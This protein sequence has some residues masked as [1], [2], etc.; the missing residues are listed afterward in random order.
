MARDGEPGIWWL[1]VMGRLAPGATREQAAQ[2]LAGTFQA[3]ALEAMPPPR[4]DGDVARLESKDYPRLIAVPGGRGLREHRRYFSRPIYGLFLVVALVLLIAC[5]NLA[6]LLLARAALRRPEIAARLA[7]GAGRGRVVRQLVT[8]AVLLAVLGARRGCA[9][10][11]LGQGGPGRSGRQR[12][13]LSGST[14]SPVSTFACS[15]SRS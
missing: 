13:P 14:S 6:N 11:G 3:A 7:L 9:V 4:R 8:E 2:S 1:N 10:R 12:Q 5:A 15:R